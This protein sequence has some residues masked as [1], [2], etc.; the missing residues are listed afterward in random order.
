[1]DYLYPLLNN[2]LHNVYSTLAALIFLGLL[3][4][5]LAKL[6]HLPSISGNIIAGMFLGPVFGIVNTNSSYMTS[7]LE[8]IA[9]LAFSLIAISIG[10]HLKFKLLHN[11]IRRILVIALVQAIVV[12]LVC[13]VGIYATQVFL[14]VSHS[15]LE[16]ALCLAVFS[17]ATAPATVVHMVKESQAKGMF[18]KTLLAVVVLNNVSNIII[19]EVCKEW[20]LGGGGQSLLPVFS[21]LFGSLALGACIAVSLVFLR[22]RIFSK[23]KEA[24]F[25]FA[26]LMIAFGL[27]I[28]LELSPAL[29]NL[30]VGVFLA[31]FSDRNQ[32]LDVFE[33]FEELIYS[34][35]F[36]L[37]GAH[38]TF[39][40][41][42]TVGVLCFAYMFFRLV[43]NMLC[44]YIS[45][46][47]T[48]LPRRVYK[49]LGMSLLPQG[50]ITVGLIVALETMSSNDLI[51]NVLTPVILLSVTITEIIGPVILR[52][53]LNR[54]G[55]AGRANPR[56]IDFIQEEF[57]TIESRKRS[58]Q[59]I[60]I[61]LVDF[62]FKT[63]PLK[64]ADKIN[65]LQSVLKR[66]KDSS[67][68]V[69]KGVAIPH[70]SLNSD[71]KTMGVMAILQH[72]LDWDSLDG[73]QVSVIILI[74]SPVGK[75]Q[76][77]LKA[78]SAISSLFLNRDSAARNLKEAKTAGDVYE[79]IADEDF[80][81]LNELVLEEQV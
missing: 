39:N 73:K 43:G 3:G 58:K 37:T 66:E 79:I 72:P 25:S 55:E 27:A 19:F 67:T 47:L 61:E 68:G 57:I 31:N 71:I 33:D 5:Y 34:L 48:P 75:P 4:G 17:I 22:T 62:L 44:L 38:A 42:Q 74:A 40:N 65:F 29:T 50:G 45:G 14:G 6:I 13:F 7:Q 11:S 36:T 76:Q 9:N 35:F 53:S 63:H 32:I 46:R 12:P 59:E 8:P 69:G 78:L 52:L 49:Y 20:M 23:K 2:P 21:K 30:T 41:L 18:V 24:I 56:L 77:H 1:M 15:P 80:E 10:S 64:I 60:I 28:E 16:I 54:S 51:S 81:S 26:A 70:G